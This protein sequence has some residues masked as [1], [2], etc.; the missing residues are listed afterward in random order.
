MT[1]AFNPWLTGL[2]LLVLVACPRPPKIEYSISTVLP[3][4]VAPGE[5]V[6][7]FG[8]LP[9]A[10]S[11][12]L[13]TLEVST[14]IIPDGLSFTVPITITAGQKTIQLS[15]T[16][17]TE[18]LEAVLSVVPRLDS[19]VLE[20]GLLRLSGVGWS[21]T[22]STTVTLNGSVIPSSRVGTELQAT[23]PSNFPYGALDVQ[24][25][26]EGATSNTL[27]LAREAGAV[28]GTV[29]L[30]AAGAAPLSL[31][32]SMPLQRALDGIALTIYPKS[33]TDLAGLELTGLE[34]RLDLPSFKA[35]QWTFK[36]PNYARVAFNA[37]QQRGIQVEWASMVSVADG[38]TASSSVAAPT[39]PGVG[40]W[41]LGLM[42]LPDV[43]KT[44]RGVG[45][46][47]AVVDTG[48]DLTHPDFQ[49]RLLP[50]Y[51][52]VDNDTQALDIAGHGSHVAGLV[53]AN[54]LALGVAREAKILPI[55]VL[56]DLSGG[57]DGPVAQGILWA[58]N[59]LEGQ[60]NPNPAQVINLSLGSNTFSS[61][62]A[63]SVGKALAKGVIVVAASGNN[64]SSSLA[65]PAALQGVVAVTALAGPVSSYQPGYAQKGIGL[66]VS[67]FGGDMNADQNNDGVSDG[68]LSL[69]INSGYALRNGTSMAAPLVAGV[70]ALA[71]SS[72]MPK[73]F[74]RDA[75]ANTAI[76]LGAKGFDTR[77]GYGLVNPK[78][79]TPFNPR[80]YA[81]LL[82][83]NAKI[84]AWS[85]VALDGVFTIGNLEPN[86]T[87]SLL[88]ATDSD[89]DGIL[90]EAG[91][92][93]SSTQNITTQSA[94]TLEVSAI[95]LNP[96]NGS[97]TLTL[98]ATK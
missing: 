37:L 16:V 88:V 39:A 32:S 77:F 44:N 81:L 59:L 83:A 15:S 89:N 3:S 36:T 34:R 74:V 95:I 31:S 4:P 8:V 64:G 45:V 23:L 73:Q 7:V 78:I 18:P 56:R 69:D 50:G 26:V 35:V 79:G 87:Y 75:L 42:G 54:G 41:H 76:D 29:V 70:A 11:L 30:P 58:A 19:A 24:V 94:K 92:M 52:F 91:E 38:L 57:S 93:I 98:E 84:L 47:V 60:D 17:L 65:F 40:Q 66:W 96:S 6:S 61:L 51:D 1:R 48:V 21:G 25:N 97:Q 90:G 10:L 27:R 62:I 71:L 46:T 55:R 43:W 9:S 2:L 12:R 13:D 20:G 5:S 82:D 53:A 72:G 68:M 85:A 67:A 49:G 33:L 14:I 22:T 28:R 80:A 63:D 86:K